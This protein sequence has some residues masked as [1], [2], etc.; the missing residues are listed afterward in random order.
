MSSPS[1]SHSSHGHGEQPLVGHLVPMS[2]LIGTGLGLILLTVVTVAVVEV[3]LGELNIVIA[4]AIAAFKATLVCLYF[5]HL[6]WDKPFNQLMFFGSI[7]FVLL[8][9]LFCLMDVGQLR[10]TI[11][12]GNPVGVQNV[13]DAEAPNAPIAKNKPQ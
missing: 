5:M 12:G 13:L 3:D 7:L 6:R 9:M 2:T 4:L 10:K 1:H 11:R 8:L